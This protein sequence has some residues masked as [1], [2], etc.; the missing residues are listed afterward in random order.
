MLAV[1]VKYTLAMMSLPQ[2]GQVAS[3]WFA[4]VGTVCWL[5]VSVISFLSLLVGRLYL[6]FV[7]EEYY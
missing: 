5:G 2:A 7:M 4:G 1:N 6:R 3:L